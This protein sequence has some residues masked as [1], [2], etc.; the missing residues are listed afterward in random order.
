MNY[1]TFITVPFFIFF[2]GFCGVF[3]NR[4]NILLVLLSIELILLS[5]NF[6]FLVSSNYLD[7]RFGQIFAV[8]VLTVAA[9]ESATG[10]AILVVYYRVKGTLS[11]YF[12]TLLKG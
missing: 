3:L 4:K 11:P 7:D 9:A 10:L 12:I 6:T 1:I 2:F 8:F 5:V